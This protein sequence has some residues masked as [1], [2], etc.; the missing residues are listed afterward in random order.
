MNRVLFTLSA[1]ALIALTLLPLVHF[2]PNRFIGGQSQSFSM[3]F[4]QHPLWVSVIVIGLVGLLGVSVFVVQTGEQYTPIMATI[5]ASL[6]LICL[7]VLLSVTSTW[8]MHDAPP[9]ARV[10]V[11]SGFW[12]C[13]LLLSLM[14]LDAW[15]RSTQKKWVIACTLLFILLISVAFTQGAFDSLSLI[16]EYRNHA[17]RFA[18]AIVRHIQLVALA[19]VPT[20]LIGLSLGYVVWRYSRVNRSVFALL[21]FLQTV[22]SIA[23]FALL[24]LPLAWLASRYQTLQDWGISGIGAAPAV[25]ALV[26]YTLLPLARNT[27]AGLSA[28][29]DATREAA[30]GMGMTRLQ[31][32][33]YVMVPL[34]LP[35]V[36]SGI[37]IVVVQAIGLTVVAAL[38]GAGG[39][40]I[41]V[42]EG[43][44]QNALDLVLLGALPTICLALL[45]DLCLQGL[46]R[47]SQPVQSVQ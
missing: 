14:L 39:L 24:M 33:R 16:K 37:R 35:I 17:E 8:L 23:L 7:F 30:R 26:L 32:F 15:Q 20:L 36:L 34:A 41:F 38:I 5:F 2:A 25:I 44:G 3:L 4:T 42:W 45:A 21:N 27:F 29:P 1:A 46:I 47:L 28:V 10:M 18:D 9:A 22:P 40:G 12:T 13:F 19:F 11:G 6:V 43:L 31:V